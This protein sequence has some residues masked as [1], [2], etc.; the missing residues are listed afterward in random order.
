MANSHKVSLLWGFSSLGFSQVQR[1]R[2]L[3]L[4]AHRNFFPGRHSRTPAGRGTPGGQRSRIPSSHHPQCPPSPGGWERNPAEICEPQASPNGL[5]STRT[6]T[7]AVSLN[8]HKTQPP[9]AQCY[10]LRTQS[11]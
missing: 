2:T 8:P 10:I 3:T 6:L 11:L 1:Q 5:A 7:L 4:S 9:E